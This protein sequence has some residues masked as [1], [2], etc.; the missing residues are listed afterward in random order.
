MNI[1][2]AA[3]LVVL[4]LVLVWL[5]IRY[6][7]FVPAVHGLPVLMYHHV[8]PE[9][10]DP[11]S[12]TPDQFE[13]QLQYLSAAG[14]QPITCQQLIEHLDRQVPLPAR[15]I[16]LTFDDGYVDNLQYAVPLLER[17]RFKATIFLPVG[18]LGET[19]RWDGGQERLL[20]AEQLAA[21]N[22]KAIELGLHSLMHDNY[23][24]MTPAQIGSDV[25]RCLK[26]LRTQGLPFAAALAYPFGKYPR[27]RATSRAMQAELKAAGVSCALRIGNRVNR[28]PLGNRYELRRINIKGSDT[29]WE[30][31]T[32]VRKG[33]VRLF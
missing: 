27:N 12:V 23:L 30:F 18:L 15:P 16:L 26:S 33:R 1:A 19:N 29:P 32:K 2:L 22:P 4:V 11:L 20:S 13:A 3:G 21:L 25:R 24:Q 6:S 28:L 14:Y 17:Y 9:R 5:V 10:R 8:H 7:L 31:R